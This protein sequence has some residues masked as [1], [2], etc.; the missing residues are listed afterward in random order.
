[1]F[2]MFKGHAYDSAQ[3]IKYCVNAIQKYAR[4]IV[5]AIG[6]PRN[7]HCL[8]LHIVFIGICGPISLQLLKNMYLKQISH[9]CLI[10]KHFISSQQD[11]EQ[12]VCMY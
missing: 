7:T 3:A 2:E 4:L 6:L 10:D 9:Y 5:L 12:L 11:K 1:M 8:R